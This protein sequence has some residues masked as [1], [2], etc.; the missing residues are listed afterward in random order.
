MPAYAP[1]AKAKRKAP[2]TQPRAS[3]AMETPLVDG[4]T[5]KLT[6][7]TPMG[8]QEMTMSIVREGD[9]FSGRIESARGSEVIKDGR[10]VGN[11]LSW[12]MQVKKPTSMKVTFEATV[13][14]DSIAGYAKLG[15]FG[16]AELTGQRVSPATGSQAGA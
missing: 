2:G 5:W 1:K 8:P 12:T 11:A 10:I 3:E 7:K 15:F 14:G 4:E 13:Q 16:K 6:L 9:A